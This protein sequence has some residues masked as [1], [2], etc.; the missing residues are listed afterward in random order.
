MQIKY[1]NF[2]DQINTKL[3]FLY[4]NCS[5]RQNIVFI[6]I[7]MLHMFQKMFYFLIFY[8]THN[9]SFMTEYTLIEDP[10]ALRIISSSST[11]TLNRSTGF[12]NIVSNSEIPILKNAKKTKI[13][14]IYGLIKLSN[15][16]YLIC[17]TKTK[18]IGIYLNN[19]IYEIKGVKFVKFKTF[20]TSE[21]DKQDLKNMQAFF[22]QP[23]LYFSD[24]PIF[25]SFVDQTYNEIDFL[26]N[27]NLLQEFDAAVRG[28]TTSFTI[29]AMQGY[30][31]I[32]KYNDYSVAL[33]SRRC[34]K[35]SGMRLFVR[36]CDSFGYPANF[37]ETEQVL[38]KEGKYDTN[39]PLVSFIQVRGSIPLKWGHR[40]NIKLNPPIVI[41]NSD[42]IIQ[43]DQI[44]R[45]HYGELFYINLI[46]HKNY[47]K[48]I[49]D[50]YRRELSKNNLS[51]LHFDFKN[52]NME[53]CL[54]TR[55]KFIKDLD[56][57]IDS[58]G[59]TI[60]NK[61]EQ[62]GVIRTNCIDSLDRTNI[63]QF[64]IGCEAIKRQYKTI[65]CNEN[66]IEPNINSLPNELN[67][68][69]RE[70]WYQNGNIIS[71]QYSGTPSLKSTIIKGGNQTIFGKLRD[72]YFSLKRYFLNRFYHGNLQNGY[73]LVTGN[74]S[75]M[76]KKRRFR[77]NLKF[78]FITM[79]FCILSIRYYMKIRKFN[80]NFY[81]MV[82]SVV[83]TY[84]TFYA[85]FFD[86]FINYPEYIEN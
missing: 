32:K 34:W 50:A 14:G 16:S 51:F 15:S 68:A 19:P 31:G 3:K 60:N 43:A 58:Q 46:Q 42:V 82:I 17:I 5:I 69:L 85:F 29:K 77:I 11:I 63:V 44:F 57:L 54:L 49:L 8:E 18:E 38:F 1:I 30:V 48:I 76:K 10:T 56:N 79:L 28:D 73:F 41:E 9:N 84:G 78:Y 53:K 27:H 47:E 39:L 21:K 22:K 65:C 24:Y 83:V 80:V 67:N 20:N 12:G 71:I 75:K 26:F 33:F 6:F 61:E 59:M 2:V 35:R 40:I 45:D 4:F 37:V 74:F 81:Y 66:N 13:S 7:L 64:L 52:Q 55:N 23:G 36:G 25:K 62:N 72:G 86:N 70:L